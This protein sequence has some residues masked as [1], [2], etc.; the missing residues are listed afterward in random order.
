MPFLPFLPHTPP[1]PRSSAPLIPPGI[2]GPPDGTPA[3]APAA[4]RLVPRRA[5][6]PP[7]PPAAE[8]GGEREEEEGGRE[9]EA[10]HVPSIRCAGAPPDARA[11]GARRALWL[12]WLGGWVDYT[13]GACA[14]GVRGQ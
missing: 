4:P 7:P 9:A 13:P 5:Y 6:F 12:G 3:E 1:L 10:E 11:A 2:L 14:R 8:G